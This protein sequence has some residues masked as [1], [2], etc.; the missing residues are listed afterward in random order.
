M[1]VYSAVCGVVLTFLTNNTL[2]LGLE[3]IAGTRE[4]MANAILL[5]GTVYYVLTLPKPA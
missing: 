2:Y 1:F 4:V 3:I 5:I